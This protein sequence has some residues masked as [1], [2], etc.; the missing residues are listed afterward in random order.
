MSLVNK[1]IITA[2]APLGVPV[3]YL[4]YSG[5]EA[6]YITFHLYRASGE[7][8]EDDEEVA[9]GHWLQVDIWSKSDYSTL[10]SEVKRRLQLAGFHLLDEADFYE[11]DVEIYHKGIKCY[12]LEHQ[13]G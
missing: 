4:R 8:Y 6:T 9:T 12:Y 5:P 1:H 2:L 13:E 10:A 11:P 3:S 7:V